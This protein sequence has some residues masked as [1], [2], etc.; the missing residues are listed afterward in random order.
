MSIFYDILNFLIN[1]FNVRK[2]CISFSLRA[3]YITIYIVPKT[4]AKSWRD[5]KVVEEKLKGKDLIDSYNSDN[6]QIIQITQTIMKCFFRVRE[7][8]RVLR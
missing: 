2:M 5:G 4:N 8:R 6:N 1:V 3:Y 7:K